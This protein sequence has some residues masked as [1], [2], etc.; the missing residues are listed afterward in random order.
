MLVKVVVRGLGLL[1]LLG[2]AHAEGLPHAQAE[3]RAAL[4]SKVRVIDSGGIPGVVLCVS[5]NAFPVVGAKCGQSVQPVAAACF[6]G[7]GRVLAVGHPSFYS[8]EGTAKADTAVFIKNGI[9]WL[10]QNKLSVAVYKNNAIA[11]A[12]THI[13][14][15]SIRE[16]PS[17]DMLSSF[18][19]LAVYPDSL[20][21]D[22]VEQVRTFITA[23]GGLL[24]SGIG[25]GW[26]QASGGKSLASE[27]LFNRLLGPAG[28]LIN[29]DYADRTAADGY[30]VDVPV[31]AGVNA[32]EALRLAAA[33]RVE[34]KVL[35]RQICQTLCAVKAVLPPQETDLSRAFD[36]LMKSPSAAK[37]PSPEK[38]LKASDLTARLSL[39]DHQSAWR[40]K[41]FDTWPAHPSAATYP[42]LPPA[43]TP[44]VA[45]T[46][47]VNLDIPRWHSTGLYAIAGEPVTVELPPGAEKLGLKVRIGTTTCDNTRHDEWRRAPKVDLEV[48]LKTNSVTV[49]SPF[50]GLVYV[51]VP[52]K[53]NV[54]SRTMKVTLRNACR[55]VWFKAGR[56]TLSAWHASL[57]DCPAPW[58]ELES[59]KII[60]TI[61]TSVVRTVDDPSA[62]LAF[63]EKVADMDAKLTAIPAARRSAERFCADVQ[64]CAGWMHA[65]YPIM[66]PEVTAK[67]LVDLD[68]LKKK[69]DWGFFHELGHN[70]QNSDWTFNGTGEVTVNFFTL[71]NMEHVCGIPPQKTRMGAESIQKTVREW[72][73]KGKTHDDWCRNPFL[74]LVTFVRLQ[75]VFGWSAFEK[76]FAEYRG[77]PQ[78]DRPKNDAEKRG[79]WASRLSRITGKNIASVFDAWNIPLTEDVRQ[80]CAKYP[81]PDDP[82]LFADV[83]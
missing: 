68:M 77:L 36:A 80:A 7:S 48:P 50:G 13:E 79:Q 63:W 43:G 73:A 33:G 6:Y 64:I 59:D 31:P 69:G 82:R 18:P 75:Q 56:D 25:W 45:R 3:A 14:G 30:Q 49:S 61:P 71:Y 44:R 15:V 38:P 66:I 16:I 34:D 2:F 21:P 12:L 83:L 24:A 11:K 32:D 47:T 8:E 57:R 72:V 78:E 62:V 67:D 5:S 4:L 37:R 40:A 41:P 23:G 39:I 26:Q 28:L 10:G 60:L 20:K 55:A 29:S 35:L 74:A 76:L 53:V 17:L 22:Q 27:N 19:V 52:D 42:G 70:H 51:V 1:S 9:A 65:G 58:A 81:K 54:A 46:L